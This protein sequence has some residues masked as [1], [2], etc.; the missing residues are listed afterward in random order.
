M[1]LTMTLL[2]VAI[3]LGGCASAQVQKVDLRT[4]EA[5]TRAIVNRQDR[6]PYSSDAVF[7]SGAYPRPQIGQEKVKPFNEAAMEQRRN[8]KTTTEIVRLEVAEAGDIAYEFFNFTL[9]YDQADTKHHTSFTGSGLRVW[10][11]VG[12]EWQVAASFMRPHDVPFAPREA[13]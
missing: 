2:G 6:L 4:D 1:N 5:A 3:A 10:K 8:E 13:Q 12:W 9:S 7:W 11:K